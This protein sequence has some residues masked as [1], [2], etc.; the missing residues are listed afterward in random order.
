MKKFL[1]NFI[2]IGPG[3]SGTTWI[4]NLLKNHP[5]ICVSSAKETLFFE[6]FYHKGLD[7]YSKFF[8]NCKN[9]V[10]IG[11]VSNTYIFSSLAAKRIWEFNPKIKL[12]SCLRNPIDRAFSHYLFLLRNAEVNGTFEGVLV[13]RKD[14]LDRGMYSKHLSKYL[15]YFPKEQILI[16]L[17]DDL[18]YDP[19]RFA[20][21]I[22]NFLNVDD[23]YYPENSDKKILAAS[24]PRIKLLAKLTKKGAQLTRRIGYPNIVTKFKTSLLPNLL[25]KQYSKNNYPVL[26]PHTR[27]KLKEYFYDDIKKTSDIIGRDLI[28]I[29]LS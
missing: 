14:L 21:K 12:I 3:K 2:V 17:Y 1:P 15:K 8:K 24:K 27:E 20:K 28:K 25:Y 18:K 29:W 22:Y 4:Y 5:Q 26:D 16:L 23:G 19:K 7:W 13:K 11:E 6:D 9:K 10:A